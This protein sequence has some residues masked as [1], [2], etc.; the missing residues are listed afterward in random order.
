MTSIGDSDENA[1]RRLH[2]RKLQRSREDVC[3]LGENERSGFPRPVAGLALDAEQERL[4][5]LWVCAQCVLDLG[6]VLDG[7]A[8]DK[9]CHGVP[10]VEEGLQG[11][12][13]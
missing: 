9:S 12:T 5:L 4:G 13:L 2:S 7:C 8:A 3:A 10:R 1:R 6:N 11:R